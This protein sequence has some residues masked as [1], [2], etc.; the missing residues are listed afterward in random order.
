MRLVHIVII[1]C[2]VIVALGFFA[3]PRTVKISGDDIVP[4]VVDHQTRIDQLLN[5]PVPASTVGMTCVTGCSNG[6]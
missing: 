2:A 3:E 5:A 1:V 6:K 4:I